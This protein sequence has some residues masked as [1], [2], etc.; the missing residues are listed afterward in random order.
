MTALVGAVFIVIVIG[1]ITVAFR[2]PKPP[3]NRPI[4]QSLVQS[5]FEEVERQVDA[6]RRQVVDGTLS[7]EQCEAQMREL[8]IQDA[9]GT[10]WMVGYES[11]AWHRNDGQG[12]VRAEP[13]R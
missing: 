5:P 6:L 10:W 2:K 8:M 11:G 7:E 3:S 9:Q 4:P 12:W 1:L 13:P